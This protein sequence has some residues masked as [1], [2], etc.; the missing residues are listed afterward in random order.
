MLNTLKAL[1]ASILPARCVFCHRQT[2]TQRPLCEGCEFDLPWTLDCCQQ[3]AMPRSKDCED[4][5]L[6]N[7][8][9]YSPPL[10]QCLFAACRYHWPIKTLMVRFKY[11][12]DFAAGRALAY[13]LAQKLL[14][15]YA[16]RPWPEILL[17]VP[18]HWSRRFY[19]GF[20]QAEW[21]AR[22][23]L[24]ELKAQAPDLE[25]PSLDSQLCQRV[26]FTPSQQGL[27]KMQ[28]EDNL[29][30]AFIVRKETLAGHSLALIDDVVTTGSTATATTRELIAAGAGDIAIWAVCRVSPK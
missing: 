21:M 3:C 16:N 26:R 4:P 17:P 9:L 11:A 2:A 27:S 29:H 25:L 5:K 23:V 8:C 1:Q 24:R 20:N 6:C 10:W 22:A 14:H 13:L 12:A 30:Q 19:R 15:E 18:L 7:V 28:R